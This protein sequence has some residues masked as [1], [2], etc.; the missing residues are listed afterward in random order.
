[1]LIHLRNMLCAF[2]L[3]I[4]TPGSYA[5]TGI[6]VSSGDFLYVLPGTVFFVD[7]LV[8]VPSTSFTINGANSETKNTTLVHPLAEANISRA[9]QFASAVKAYSG[10]IS[11]Y[12][13][14]AALNGIPEAKVSLHI[15]NGSNWTAYTSST[16]RGSIHNCVTA[17]GLHNVSLNELTLAYGTILN[18]D[19]TAVAT[20]FNENSNAS[21]QQMNENHTLSVQTF[22]NPASQYFT[23]LINS[24]PGKPVTIRVTDVRGKT[25]EVMSNISAKGSA[26]IGYNY[27]PGIYFA[28]VMQGTRKV[29]VKLIKQSK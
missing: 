17:A 13:P 3:C 7:S 23:L 15:H 5:Q 20:D 16:V 22:P 21:K 11:M 1:M 8:L 25:L 14:D 27:Q 4:C 6:S 24:N 19:A 2:C 26:R 9:Y 28:E 12:Y 18:H 29:T 10:N